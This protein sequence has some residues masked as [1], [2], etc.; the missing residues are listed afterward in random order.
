[1]NLREKMKGRIFHV[2]WN[3]YPVYGG[4]ESFILES[5]K[6]LVKNGYDVTVIASNKLPHS[7]RSLP[8][9][10]KVDGVKI[11][12]FHYKKYS[13][14]NTSVD[15]LKFILNSDFDILHVHGIGFFSDVI[16]LVKFLRGKKIVLSTHGGIF[17][18]KVFT[19]VKNVYFT[20]LA[21][22]AGRY[23]DQV[24]AVSNQDKI[25]MEK[26]MD[27]KKIKIIKNGIDWKGLSKIKR[28]GNGST[29]LFMGRIAT[30]K[31][32]ERILHIVKK[33]Q[34]FLP[35]VQL[36]VVGEDWGELNHLKLLAKKLEIGKAVKFTGPLETGKLRK[37]FATSDLF[38]LASDYEGFGIS[39]IE[40]MAAGIPV[41]VNDIESMRELVKNGKNGFRTDFTDYEKTSKLIA[42]I[43]QNKKLMGELSTNGR[44]YARQFDWEVVAKKLE[45]LYDDLMK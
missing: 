16:P 22:I 20:T 33:L 8:R 24:I 1:M 44:N 34:E 6:I 29:L 13:R 32:I 43:L 5:S 14:Y 11:R 42:K 45:N 36:I 30:N 10:A 4:I 19:L 28:N 38:L 15:A 18:T 35:E 25:F 26:I 40:A 27:K 12:R 17:H 3:F 2:C 37:I 9:T 7:N 39:V 41:V 21:R 31:K 23:V